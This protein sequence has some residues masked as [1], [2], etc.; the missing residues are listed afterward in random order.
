M[1]RA[2]APAAIVAV[3]ACARH[4]AAAAP[5]ACPGT[6]VMEVTNAS[7]ASVETYWVDGGQT[8]YLGTAPPG[9]TSLVAGRATGTPRFE[10]AGRLVMG[11]MA[12]SLSYQLYCR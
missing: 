12:S 10:Q 2:L 1:M 6:L 9:T 3:I 4:P 11:R 7:S 8:T 5:E